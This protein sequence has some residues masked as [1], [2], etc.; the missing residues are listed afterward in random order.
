MKVCY[1]GI[2]KEDFT[3]SRVILMALKSQGFKV[4]VCVDRTPSLKKY[5]NLI[6]KHKKIKNDYDIMLVGF[7]GY[8]VMFLARFLTR[9]PIIFDSYIS[10]YDGLLDRRS[11]S[12]WNPRMIFAW[13]VDFF[14]A[15]CA[16]VVLTINGQYKN[17]FVETLKVPSSK[18]EVLHKGADETVFYLRQNDDYTKKQKYKVVWWGTY[19]P[20]H[21]VSYI[22]EAA[23]LLRNESNV[24]FRMIGK[25][26]LKNETKSKI[27]QLKLT[28]IFLRDS[29]P[30]DQLVDEISGADITLGIFNSSPKASRCVTNKVYEA[31]A[32]G[33]AIITEDSLANREIFTHK[34]NAFLIPPANPTVLASAI[35]ELIEDSVLRKKI[36]QGALNTFRE[37][38][39]SRM[40]GVEFSDI[41][42]RHGLFTFTD[43]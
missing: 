17:F 11:Y 8:F 19:I 25:G 34:Q 7:P 16:R 1:F 31:M 36:A 14:S 18:M 5:F 28:N 37:R 41:L 6:K 43:K 24:E 12:K 15:A 26:Q 30:I 39:V 33:K 13:C 3:R 9:R 22:V 21:G 20:L 27:E 10:Y 40:I 42:K 4:T 2:F 38:F 35:E 29:L 23:N 32:M